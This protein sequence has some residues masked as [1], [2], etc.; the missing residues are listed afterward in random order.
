MLAKHFEKEISSP[1]LDA[2]PHSKQLR[3]I[4]LIV[5]LRYVRSCL[6]IC[7]R[8]RFASIGLAISEGLRFPLQRWVEG[9]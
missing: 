2:S 6:R 9:A 3:R 8:L 1:A 7:Q 5:G 4:I